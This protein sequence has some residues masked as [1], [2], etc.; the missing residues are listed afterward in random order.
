MLRSLD[1]KMNRC[2]NVKLFNILAFSHAMK[3][4]W[5]VK[6]KGEPAL[7]VTSPEEYCGISTSPQLRSI[8]RDV[9]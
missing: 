8:S 7:S 9:L 1:N 2:I 6:E 3:F 4:I 5:I